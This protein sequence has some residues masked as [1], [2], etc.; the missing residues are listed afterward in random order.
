MHP[1]GYVTNYDLNYGWRRAPE[2]AA[3]YRDQASLGV[4]DPLPRRTPQSTLGCVENTAN[5]G[6][7]AAWPEDESAQTVEQGPSWRRRHDAQRGLRQNTLRRN[8]A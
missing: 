5:K 8:Q 6:C 2:C 4:S 7:R 1:W 3:L